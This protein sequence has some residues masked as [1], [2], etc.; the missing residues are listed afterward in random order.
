MGKEV[1]WL[2]RHELDEDQV[3][4][5]KALYG[6]D[7]TVNHIDKMIN[8]AYEL[9]D[10]IARAD[11]VAIVAPVNMQKQFLD[12][13][14]EDKPVIMAKS[15]RVLV[16]QQDGTESKVQFAF[17]SWEKLDKV[18][19]QT[20]QFE[21]ENKEQ[22]AG[23]E[24]PVKVMWLSRH[25]MQPEQLGAIQ[26][27]FPGREI[28][29]NKVD[30]TVPN[31]YAIQDE[32][33]NAD[34]V[35]MVAPIQI[36]EQALKIAGP[37]KPVITAQ[38]DMTSGSPQ[39]VQWNQVDAI[40]VQKDTLITKE[41][42]DNFVRQAD[43]ARDLVESGALTVEAEKKG[44]VLARPAKEGEE[45]D[46]WT[47]DGNYEGHETAQ[48][49][50][51]ILTRA[52]DNGQPVIDENGHTNTW[53]V[54]EETFKKKYDTEHQ[55]PETG[56]VKPA[57]GTQV[58]VQTDRDITMMAPWGEMQNIQAGGFLNITDPK[59]VYGIANE[60]FNETYKV[61]GDVTR[62]V[63]Y[64]IEDTADLS[65]EDESMDEYD[66]YYDDLDDPDDYDD[67]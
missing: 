14:G 2:S 8:N 40:S 48:K 43:Y 52:D 31:A 23:A 32:I 49:G 55:D 39:F 24:E 66:D 19:V 65:M 45:L 25:D 61:T 11:V 53:K 5:L 16:P 12:I 17:N 67:R 42:V 34:V 36:Q 44:A 27:Q 59:D 18:E 29:I 47:K 60:E 6:D 10:D 21:M 64:G 41:Q 7:M 63:E 9:K 35:A 56:F 15:D 33:Q 57:G 26:E 51:I 37:D 28:E 30:K 54:S 3:K 4:G 58:F 46:V 1:M 50:D 38:M 62:D 22:E 13:A 20:H